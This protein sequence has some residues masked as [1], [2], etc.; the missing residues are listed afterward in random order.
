MEM[1]LFLCTSFEG[2]NWTLEPTHNP[3]EC[4]FTWIQANLWAPVSTDTYLLHCSLLGC[5]K[6]FSK[7]KTVTKLGF[8]KLFLEQEEVC[9]SGHPLGNGCLHTTSFHPNILATEIV[10]AG[11]SL[12]RTTIT[13]LCFMLFTVNSTGLF[14][15]PTLCQAFFQNGTRP[16]SMP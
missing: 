5:A 3:G 14:H 6:I 11:N 16:P 13:C 2:M 10:L 12:Q 1:V 8:L 15:A 9:A 4:L 7:A